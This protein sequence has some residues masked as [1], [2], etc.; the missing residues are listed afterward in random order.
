M[1]NRY[2]VLKNGK[3][4]EEM[5]ALDFRATSCHEQVETTDNRVD[6]LARLLR[7]LEDR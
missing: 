1:S 7:N 2:K 4:V 3:G 6:F 5:N